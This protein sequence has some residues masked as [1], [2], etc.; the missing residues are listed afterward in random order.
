MGVGVVGYSTGE[1]TM[2]CHRDLATSHHRPSM[3][4][5]TAWRANRAATRGVV[6]LPM[7][8]SSTVSPTK[9][10]IRISRYGSSSGKGAGCNVFLSP[11]NAHRASTHA[12]RSRGGIFDAF[13]SC[14]VG[15]RLGRPGFLNSRMNSWLNSGSD[16]LG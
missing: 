6:P 15:D 8:G 7:N 4:I 12:F 13:F 11:G 16:S 10:N 14:S 5:P 3:S 9:E 2:E 1:P